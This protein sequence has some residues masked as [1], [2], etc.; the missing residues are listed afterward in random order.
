MQ[1][2][3]IAAAVA[4]LATTLSSV[5]SGQSITLTVNCSRIDPLGRIARA[6]ARKRGR[7]CP[8]HLQRIRDHRP[9][10]RDPARRSGSGGAVNGPGS[11]A[12]AVT[13][14]GDRTALENLT[15]TGGANGVLVS[16]PYAV[17]MS[18]VVVQDP[19]SGNAVLVRGS[20]YL[21]VSG[22]KLM[23]A[24]TGL[25]VTRGASARVSGG[26][27]IRDNSGLGI[28][29]YNNGTLLMSGNSKV[30]DNGGPA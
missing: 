10:R 29:V 19:A 6:N 2:M 20:G 8:R 27:E 28:N 7:F 24:Q 16:G 15:V 21:S 12:A 11:A 13:V 5:A 3:L 26:T 23:H 25:N 30:L 9:G 4:L 22:S 18:N 1:R 14:Q 17:T